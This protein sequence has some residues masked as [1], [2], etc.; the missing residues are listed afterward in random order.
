MA[1]RTHSGWVAEDPSIRSRKLRARQGM[2]S[3]MGYRQQH[4]GGGILKDRQVGRLRRVFNTYGRL[5]AEITSGRLPAGRGATVIL[6]TN[7][8]GTALYSPHWRDARMRKAIV[9]AV[10]MLCGFAFVASVVTRS[11]TSIRRFVAYV[12]SGSRSFG[13][14]FRS[15]SE[16]R[17]E[18][19]S[20]RKRVSLPT[21]QR[22][23]RA[24]IGLHVTTKGVTVAKAVR[25]GR[26]QSR[27][28]YSQTRRTFRLRGRLRG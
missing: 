27:A 11:G 19:R 16:T 24:L 7:R 20:R 18:T 6:R 4:R 10:L 8:C 23:N 3:P 21:Q 15:P 26:P 1:E 28:E 22:N 9:V 5:S 17:I 13:N 14:W 2:A 25:M 12:D